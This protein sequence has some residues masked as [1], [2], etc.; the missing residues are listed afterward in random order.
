MSILLVE[1][2]TPGFE[3]S[4][5]IGKLGYKGP[6]SCEVALT[7]VRVPA[8][9]LVGGVEGTGLKQALSSLEIGRVNIAA[10]AVGIA[11]AAL[12]QALAYS[13]E[14]EAFGVPISDFQAIQLK[15]ADMATKVEAGRLLMWWAAAKFDRGERSDRE[16]GMA[17]LFCSETAIECAL[18]AMR[19]HGGYGY[20]TE[21][22]VER[23]YR[24]APLMAIGEGTNDIL[25]LVI[26]RSLLREGV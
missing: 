11:G 16:S 10:R 24:D 25:R 7:D 13:K 19:I 23:L 2:G 20:S 12:E 18:E 21:F 1:Q 8:A 17:K 9:N 22:E 6:E 4:R 26:A 14:R 3:V 5:D 15:L